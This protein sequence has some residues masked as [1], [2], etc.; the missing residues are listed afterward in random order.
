MR[1]LITNDDGFDAPG[2]AALYLALAELGDVDVVAPAVCHSAKGHAVNTKEAIRVDQ[3]SLDPFGKIYV[4]HA[5]P[6]DC[7]RIGLRGLGLKQPDFVVAGINPGANL[8][9][10]LYYSGTA[11]AAREAAIL[12]IPSLAVSRYIRPPA[13]INWD[14]L[15]HH[16]RRIVGQLI[17]DDHR[18]P[19]GQFWNVNFPA[20]PD[21]DHPT[22][23]T[24]APMGLL[25]HAIDYEARQEDGETTYLNYNADFRGRGTTGRCDVS[26]VLEGRITVTPVDL[27]T[28]AP[29]AFFAPCENIAND[30]GNA[31]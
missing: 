30:A 13:G 8:G 15:A 2:L 5:S 20:I 4:A 25:S 16:T 12:G 6:A 9:V 27:C 29:H 18:L 31:V 1:F 11:A 10:D 19:S 7:V 14:Q 3:K 17:A 23:F 22:D 26:H 24:I 21:D 28:T